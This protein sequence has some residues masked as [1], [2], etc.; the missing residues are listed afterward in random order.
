[1]TKT[2]IRNAILAAVVAAAPFA[3]PSEAHAVSNCVTRSVSSTYT[4]TTWLQKTVCN[5][6]EIAVSAGG[7][8]SAAGDMKGVSTTSGTTDR[9]VWLWCN[10][11]GQAYWYAVCCQP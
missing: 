10:Q 9:L 8:C 11:P 6:G 1:M 2:T 5:A 7:F 3:A 4:G